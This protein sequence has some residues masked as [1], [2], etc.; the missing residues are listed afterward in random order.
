[1]ANTH[2]LTL[3]DLKQ[4]A[5][6]PRTITPLALEQMKRSYEKYGDLSGIVYNETTGNL[7]GGHQRHT[8]FNKSGA[9]IILKPYKDSRGT[10]AIGHVV[11]PPSTPNGSVLRIPYRQVKFDV[12]TEKGA[13]IAANAAGG[14]F[15]P[16]KLGRILK[17]LEYAKFPIENVPLDATAFKQAIRMFESMERKKAE[18]GSGGSFDVIDTDAMEDSLEHTCP[19]CN[20]RWSGS[21]KAAAFNKK[22]ATPVEAPRRRPVQEERRSRR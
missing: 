16:V 10:T 7:I 11:V 12:N 8:L 21:T 14:D 4:A 1:M 17:D 6:N 5:Y 15:D 9:K 13:N 2:P 22:E 20:Y 3:R 18:T 19:R